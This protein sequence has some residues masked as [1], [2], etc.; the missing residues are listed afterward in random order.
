MRGRPVHPHLAGRVIRLDEARALGLTDADLR[1]VA[2]RRVAPRVWADATVH[3]DELG[4]AAACAASLEPP[5]V[6]AG[7][8]AAL[9][10]GADVGL[11][12]E[13]VQLAVRGP[14]PRAR[15][16]WVVARDALPDEDVCEADGVL[17]T[18][19]LRTAV[20]LARGLPLGRPVP[21]DRATLEAVVGLDGVCRETGVPL[22]AVRSRL[23]GLPPRARGRA[24]GL[25]AVSL[26]DPR[27]E[28]PQETRTRV[29]L[30]AAGLPPPQVQLEVRG[31][32]GRRR[33]LDLAY[34]EVMVGVEYDG[35]VH[36]TR[37][38]A[39]LKRHASLCPPWVL[40]R[41]GRGD[42]PARP[43]VLVRWTWEALR[44][45]GW[46]LR[47]CAPFRWPAP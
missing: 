42:V 41:V 12:G 39:D 11:R 35:E 20:D 16:G 21:R 10:H 13:P 44:S 7:T 25:L 19:P 28:S 30:V 34:E 9:A 5:G 22:A 24:R 45:H 1:G 36:G 33:R 47:E 17:L 6:L 29:A 8:T 15:P 43:A 4:R 32:D 38:D 26:A 2:Y 27:A 14:R 3:L 23:E 37:L 31:R 18:T 46:D 40:V